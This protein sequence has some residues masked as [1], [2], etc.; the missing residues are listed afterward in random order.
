MYG[1]K[2]RCGGKVYGSGGCQCGE[3]V[4]L[5]LVVE[6]GV[7]CDRGEAPLEKR[8][9]CLHQHATTSLALTEAGRAIFLSDFASLNDSTSKLQAI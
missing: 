7:P 5:R 4:N 3:L 2:D 1:S 6:E 8:A 9:T